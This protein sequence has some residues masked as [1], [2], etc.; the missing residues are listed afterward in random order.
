VWLT[1]N[2]LS[3]I[4]A[5]TIDNNFLSVVYVPKGGVTD[6]DTRKGVGVLFYG[7]GGT[8]W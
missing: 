7:A 3:G 5:E 6:K 4:L 2:N 1:R 8:E